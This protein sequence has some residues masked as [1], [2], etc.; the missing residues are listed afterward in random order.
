MLET[1]SFSFGV[2]T[3][4]IATLLVMMVIYMCKH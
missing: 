1:I 4:V 3:G 2:L